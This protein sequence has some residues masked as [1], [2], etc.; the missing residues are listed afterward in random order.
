MITYENVRFRPRSLGPT[1]SSKRSMRLATLDAICGSPGYR[2]PAYA[3]LPHIVKFS[4]GRSSA[5]MTL[6]LA[7]SRSLR[8]DRGDLVLFANT[9]AEHPATYD[10]AAK[11]CDEIEDEHGVPCLW[12][13]FCTV[14]VASRTG[15]TRAG[16]YRL[17][18]RVRASIDDEPA[19]PGY[20]DDGTA[21]EELAS[22]KA[23][24]PNRSVRICTQ[25]LKVLPGIEL[26]AHW[27]GGG[28]G[29]PHS[30]HYHARR[31]VSAEDS[32]ARYSGTR[33]TAEECL[34]VR[35]FV[36][37]CNRARP[38]QLWSDFVSVPLMKPKQGPRPSADLAGRTGA[39]VRFVTLLGLRADE[40][41]RVNRAH[42][43][44]MLADGAAGAHC[45]HESHPAGE[46]MAT[47]LA[48]AGS[49]KFAVENFWRRQPYDLAI[50]GTAGNC[51]YCFMKGETALRNLAAAEQGNGR[52]LSGPSSIAWWADIERR[53]AGASDHP[54]SKRFK[55]LTLRSPTYA[56]IAENPRAKRSAAATGL[57]CACTD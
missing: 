45:R 33:M 9:T 5:A 19:T 13:E 6:S 48:D 24:L 4:G 22:L 20:L 27:L 36:H 30:G 39:P 51:V 8:A 34:E 29:P 44:S 35:S 57:P 42:F 12:Y 10:F 1:V 50:D 28:P 55:F 17:V 43:E 52:A 38:A 21:F 40:P 18:R 26:I 46:V 53:Y 49:D 16:S 31:L 7:R 32:A 41:K 37:D 15:W 11:V 47:P 14:E 54:D 23:M 3:D 56:E 2:N 25:H